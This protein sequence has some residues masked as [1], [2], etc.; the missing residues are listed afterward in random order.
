MA[1][2]QPYLAVVQV[3]LEILI[4]EAK[5]PTE[6]NRLDLVKKAFEEMGFRGAEVLSVEPIPEVK[7]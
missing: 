6:E 1:D 7:H 3:P 4:D 2:M 5:Y